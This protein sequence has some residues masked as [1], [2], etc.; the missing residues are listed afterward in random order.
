ML[1]GVR[2]AIYMCFCA[3]MAVGCGGGSTNSA[4]SNNPG[5]PSSSGNPPSSSSQPGT[6][7]GSG[8][9]NSSGNGSSSSGE[10][11]SAGGSSGS[12]TGTTGGQYV[13]VGDSDKLQIDG[14]KVNSDGMLTAVPGSPFQMSGQG[15]SYQ[16][17]GNTL[18]V[19]GQFLFTNAT[20]ASSGIS[21]F[22][23]DPATGSLSPV[24]TSSSTGGTWFLLAGNSQQN[25]LF[26]S[27][28]VVTASG[29]SGSAAINGIVAYSVNSDGSLKP[30][31]TVTMQ[32]NQPIA[33]AIAF[34]N[35]SRFLYSW[36]SGEIYVFSLNGGSIGSQV[37]GSPFKIST[38][39]Q[40]TSPNDPNACFGANEKP[41]L[42][43]DP[44][45]GRFLY[46]S[47]DANAQVDEIAVS[48]S[49]QLTVVG[50]VSSPGPSSELSSL[51]MSNDGSLLFGTEEEANSVISFRV[52]RSTGQLSLAG[53]VTA[54]TRPNQAAGDAS[55]H[56]L[57]VTNGSSNLSKND[58]YPGSNN[59]SQ[60]AVNA[61]V[62]TPLPDSPKTVGSRPT[63]VIAVK[64]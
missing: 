31:S 36:S 46:A 60:C 25:V 47:C 8:S 10:S 63:S 30:I 37:S 51:I 57:S 2:L 45:G 22:K 21:G 42:A 24:N 6:S 61:G 27:G 52:D 41:I 49:G 64:F 13:Y 16:T 20:T 15:E 29:G 28:D 43:S 35:Q 32:N 53:T 48:S 26:A 14:F 7:S 55:N 54:G 33:G 34:D 9:G 38:A 58:Y 18:A 44:A 23:I 4:S 19:V 5:A 17:A 11:G 56:Y 50:T 3:F 40:P 39:Y 1:R 59:L 62:M 12:G